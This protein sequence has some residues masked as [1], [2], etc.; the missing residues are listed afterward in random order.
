MPR[1]AD[2][3][4]DSWRHRRMADSYS[5]A[6]Q[7]VFNTSFTT[8]AAFVSTAI[9][10]IMPIST[11]GIYASI[12]IVVNYLFVISLTPSA[13][14]LHEKYMGG[15]GPGGPCWVNL[16]LAKVGVR[17]LPSQDESAAAQG[18]SEAPLEEKTA[19]AH[20]SVLQSVKADTCVKDE[21]GQNGGANGAK[22]LGDEERAS[23]V[24]GGSLRVDR[25]PTAQAALAVDDKT[26]MLGRVLVAVFEYE[27]PPSFPVPWLRGAKLLSW[28]CVLGCLA[29]GVTLL[30][31][32]SMLSLPVEQEQFLPVDH[33][34]QRFTDGSVKFLTSSGDSYPMMNL[35]WGA[36]PDIKRPNFDPYKPDDNRGKAVLDK[37]FDLSDPQAFN[38]V[39]DACAKLR[40]KTCGKSKAC[41]PLGTMVRP[42]SVT[43]AVDEFETWHLAQYGASAT[44][45]GQGGVTAADFYSRLLTF[46]ETTTPAADPYGSWEDL[47]G[48]VDGKFAY[49]VVQGSATVSFQAIN[50]DKGELLEVSEELVSE[51]EK[52]PTA[53]HV[54][55]VSTLWVWYATNVALIEGMITGLAIAFPVAF[56]VLAAATQNL[57]I[58]L[59]AILS[60]LMIV[61]SVLGVAQ[62][63]GWSLGI[64]ESIAA[65]IVVGFSVDYT[66]H[67]GHMY[68]HAGKHL[69]FE[70]RHERARYAILKMSSTVLAG[71]ITTAGSGSFMFA[72]QIVFFKKM[73]FLICV[74]IAF[75]LLFSLFLF[76][77]LLYVA[78]PAGNCG[79]VAHFLPCLCA[80]PS[81]SGAS[82]GGLA[83]AGST[84]ALA[85]TAG[86]V[87]AHQ[88][89]S[90]PARL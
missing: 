18:G 80:A 23:G 47:I 49:L 54:L 5:R 17:A 1:R 13:I 15:F 84:G 57:L 64:I 9:S 2:E 56:L 63:E 16:L 41:D 60:I 67:M 7:A 75:S 82:N 61:G 62:R 42:D 38:A 6:M 50:G 83:S 52:P 44:D 73:G 81:T 21:R 26:E 40:V 77:P 37:N 76:M 71:A 28:G 36:K 55:Q 25:S 68:D 4:F 27:A 53:R 72:C 19:V 79:H 33:V 32:A 45:R 65:V 12:C 89:N 70:A 43:C 8:T 90:A 22:Q 74:T 35:V 51:L 31:Y 58:A 20:A 46:R 10:P 24:V 39:A 86:P 3:S 78:G 66:I 87:K 59:Y 88:N 11:F 34:V 85:T 69:G 14:I 30:A 29:T 48:V